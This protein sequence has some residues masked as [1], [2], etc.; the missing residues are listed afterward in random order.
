[1]SD[2]NDESVQDS[3]TPK[4]YRIILNPN[5][6]DVDK[7]FSFNGNVWITITPNDDNIKMIELDATNLDIRTED[8]SVYRSRIL[9]DSDFDLGNHVGK[10][11][12]QLIE[13][14]VSIEDDQFDILMNSTEVIDSNLTTSAEK[15][16]QEL[17]DN[18]T[19]ET[20]TTTEVDLNESQTTEE[21]ETEENAPTDDSSASVTEPSDY[22]NETIIWDGLQPND[23]ILLETNPDDQTELQIDDI[24]INM[25]RRKMIIKLNLALRKG[26]YYIVKVFF[27]GEMSDENGLVYKAYNGTEAND[28]FS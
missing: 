10:R 11:S 14:D 22:N 21:S 6:H 1:M 15:E 9:S 18:E 8:V 27:R 23:A 20:I 25:E 16:S 12:A 4:H 26:H 19:D 3:I 24:Q 17:I 5:L 7:Q 13:E 2:N 28:R